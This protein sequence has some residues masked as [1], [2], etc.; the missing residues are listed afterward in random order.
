V[1]EP[2]GPITPARLLIFSQEA[3]DSKEI[4]AFFPPDAL[5]PLLPDNGRLRVER[6]GTNSFDVLLNSAP[7]YSASE[8][9]EWSDQFEPDLGLIREALKRPV[10]RMAGDYSQ[11]AQIPVPDFVCVRIVA[12]T[13]SQRAQACLLL[14]NGDQALRELTLLHDLGRLLEAKPTTLVAAMIKVAIT[15]LYVATVADGLRLKV[16]QERELAALQ[17]QFAE[18]DLAPPVLDAFRE[19]RASVCRTL[20]MT[21]SGELPRLWSGRSIT[22]LRQ[23]VTDPSFWILRNVPRGWIYQNMVVFAS[24]EQK[25]LECFDS[26]HHT[27]SGQRIEAVCR[28]TEKSLRRFAPGTFIA[29]MATPNFVRACQTMAITQTKVNQAQIACA[30]ERYRLAEGHPPASLGNASPRFL[31]KVP[32]D[33]MTGHAF[34]YLLKDNDRFILYSVG[35]N[36]KDDGGFVAKMPGGRVDPAYGDWVWDSDQPGL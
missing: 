1:Q 22:G 13:L 31:D 33:L 34:H 15:G 16:W 11:P 19:E 27:M 24:N 23:K 26:L 12:Q 21:P 5:A 20:E 35:W 6:T 2:L 32:D 4:S 14:G 8:Y 28:E 10:A 7:C 3:P 30:I 25:L 18:T 36:Q 9:L 29:A 17:A